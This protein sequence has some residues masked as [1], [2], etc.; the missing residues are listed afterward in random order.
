MQLYMVTKG[1]LGGARPRGICVSLM[2][3]ETTFRQ[4]SN[5][6]VY[7]SKFSNSMLRKNTEQHVDP[8]R[9]DFGGFANN[10]SGA[11]NAA[12]R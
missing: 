5:S 10:Y 9:E 3:A 2:N 12:I 8:Y 1:S 6:H 7:I 4:W 11:T